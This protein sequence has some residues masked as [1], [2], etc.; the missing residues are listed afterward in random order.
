MEISETIQSVSR[1]LRLVKIPYKFISL[2]HLAF[3]GP[4]FLYIG[5]GDKHTDLEY[6][7]LFLVAAF[8][9]LSVRYH[10]NISNIYSVS[11]NLHWILFFGLLVYTALMKNKTHKYILLSYKYLGVAVIL[12]HLY[13][14]LFTR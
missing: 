14:Q 2:F 11:H 1:S 13:L 12:V 5:N 10:D 6:N 3:V 8:I 9:L 4:L 7:M